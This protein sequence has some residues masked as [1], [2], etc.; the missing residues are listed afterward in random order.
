M[1]G[2]KAT[3]GAVDRRE[4]L[5]GR[6]GDVLA[7][8]GLQTD[9]AVSADARAGFAQVAQQDAPSA[10]GGLG[11]IDQGVEPAVLDPLLG[12]IGFGV[13]DEAPQLGHVAG[14]MHHPGHGG[15]AVAAGP[16]G[17]LVVG[18][19]TLGQIDVGH[20]AHV[21]FVDAHA[22]G[23]G[24]HHDHA[25][26]MAETLQAGGPLRG[27][28]PG[29]VRQGVVARRHQGGGELFHALSG[30]GIDD[31]G[32]APLAGQEIEQLTSGFE[33][34]PQQVADVGTIEA[35]GEHRRPLQPQA[36]H[37]LGAGAG[38]GG[39]G[40]GDAG[41]GPETLRQHGQ[42]QVFRAGS[43]GPTGRRSGP[44]RSRT[45][46]GAAGPAGRSDRR[47]AGAPERHRADPA[48]RPGASARWRRRPREVLRNAG[49]PPAPPPGA[50]PPP[51]P[52]SGRSAATPP[53]PSP[54]G[55]GPESGSR[56]TCRR[57]W[58]SAPGRNRQRRRARR[59]PPGDRG[60]C[61][62]RTRPAARPWAGASW[63]WRCGLH[64][65]AMVLAGVV[66]RASLRSQEGSLPHSRETGGRSGRMP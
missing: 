38:V 37:D 28:Q 40:E 62:S 49:R 1:G 14:A 15:E 19:Q 27:R 9:V 25:A 43:H 54:A 35:G 66:H 52:A 12:G 6:F 61:H 5:A 7:L 60:S 57:R 47:P 46:P 21:R 11:E 18:L 34:V 48:R 56:G 64:R 22:E 36:R 17:L 30:T 45:G 51:G 42:L 24:G 41:N 26:A 59:S 29:V 55:R 65:L 31:A 8:V 4:G 2:A 23:D 39:G 33:L 10:A 20:E 16:A 44:R 63:R 3:A 50:A 13:F 32:V 53:P 58:A